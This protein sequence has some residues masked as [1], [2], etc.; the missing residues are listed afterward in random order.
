V[1]AFQTASLR[2]SNA[3]EKKD[4]WTLLR[5][6]FKA[7]PESECLRLERVLELT[8]QSVDESHPP[9]ADRRKVVN[10]AN[11]SGRCKLSEDRFFRIREELSVYKEAMEYKIRDRCLE[12]IM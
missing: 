12:E 2:F 5:D 9:T 1:T 7:Y 8:A 6:E 3:Y 10:A 11:E 4:F